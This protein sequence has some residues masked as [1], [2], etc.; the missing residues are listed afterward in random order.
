MSQRTATNRT[1]ALCYL[2]KS[3]V[4]SGVDY[5]SVEIQRAAIAEFCARR[6]WVTEWYED[7]EGH[8][9][10]RYE[11]GRPAWLRLKRRV[12]DPDVAIV[13][14]YKFDRLGRSV[15]DLIAFI[16]YCISREVD[17]QTVDGTLNVSGRINAIASAQINMLAT[18]AQFESS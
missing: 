5:A 7:A 9:S 15:K 10:G 8:S 14:G 13:V 18:F 2:R 16:Q 4:R 17:V 1:V 11:T 12:A 3:V 6:G